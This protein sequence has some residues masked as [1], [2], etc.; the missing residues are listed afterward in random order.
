MAALGWGWHGD[1]VRYAGTHAGGVD[2]DNRRM[3]GNLVCHMGDDST[4]RGTTRVHRLNDA[5]RCRECQ[6]HSLL[7]TSSLPSHSLITAS[8]QPP[9]SLLTAPSQPP[10]CLL[11]AST[12]PPRQAADK[13]KKSRTTS[14]NGVRF[15][16]PV[17]T[18][19]CYCGRKTQAEIWTQLFCKP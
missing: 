11:T 5:G 4:R 2:E 17:Y 1:E 6:S 3:Y 13:R 12:P 18:W 10:H 15:L 8:S 16:I 14:K 19:R 9:H 7:T